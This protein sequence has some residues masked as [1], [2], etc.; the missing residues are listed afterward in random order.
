MKV[1]V[2]FEKKI[3]KK[4]NWTVPIVEFS[5]TYRTG[6]NLEYKKMTGEVPLTSEEEALYPFVI[7]PNNF[8]KLPHGRM[9]DLDIAS[10]KAMYDLVML[11]GKFAKSKPEFMKAVHYGYFEDKEIEASV[12][13]TDVVDETAALS[14]ILSLNALEI[15]S[16]ALMLSYS[17]RREDFDINVNNSTINQKKAAMIKLARK[18]PK[19][20]LN[21]FEEYNPNVKDDLFIYKL[22]HHKLIIKTVTDFYESTSTGKGR[23]LGKNIN[24]VKDFLNNKSNFSMRDKFLNLIK[25]YETGMVVTIPMSE[26]ENKINPEDKKKMLVSQIK[27][28]LFDGELTEASEKLEKLRGVSEK[29]DDTFASLVMAYN[30]ACEEVK[31]TEKEKR[32]KD[33]TEQYNNMD[34]PK[35]IALFNV[36]SSKFVFADIEHFKE[37]KEKV[38]EYMVNTL[39]KQ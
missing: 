18:T 28:H 4:Y 27:A 2:V 23:Y 10:D 21:C 35:L 1:R 8:Y 25:Q 34:L 38:I 20:V 11:S 33:L 30:K 19:V 16:V 12:L 39:T 17:T 31:S 9:L 36:K 37:D 7:N 24:D 3:Y 14:K 15:D 13:I 22:I 26:V 6:Q 29:N 32:I 5:G